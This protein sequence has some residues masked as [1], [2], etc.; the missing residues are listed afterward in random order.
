MPDAAGGGSANRVPAVIH[1]LVHSL[2][3]VSRWKANLTVTSRNQREQTATCGEHDVVRRVGWN[4]G[5]GADVIRCSRRIETWVAMRN[6]SERV[7][8]LTAS[9][10]RP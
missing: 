3:V 9:G 8:S 1:R 10:Q 5:V 6:Q 2:W 4:A 7:L